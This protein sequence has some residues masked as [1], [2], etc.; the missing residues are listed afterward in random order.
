MHYLQSCSMSI[1]FIWEI[2]GFRLDGLAEL[3]QLA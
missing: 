2:V 1:P 3:E